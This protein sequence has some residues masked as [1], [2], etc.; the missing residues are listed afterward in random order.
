MTSLDPAELPIFVGDWQEFNIG[1]LFDINKGHRLTKAN[2]IPGKINYV[3]ASADNNGV[4]H[5]I[6]NKDYVFNAGSITVTYN[7]SVGQVFYQ[8]EPFWATDDVNVLTLK[9]DQSVNVKLFL[10]SCLRQSGKRYGFAD[11]WTVSKMKK[12]VIK[13]PVDIN[14]NPDWQYM[15]K[16]VS[17]LQ[18]RVQRQL[19]QYWLV[20]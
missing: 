3:G 13:L 9:E 1:Q 8:N 5:H 2:M 7:G 17:L 15:N 18:Q 6:G 10:M 11:K 12:D 19:C 4:T 16:H 20:V 14:G